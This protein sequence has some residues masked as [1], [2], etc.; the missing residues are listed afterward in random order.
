[1]NSASVLLH[2]MTQQK[3]RRP[4]EEKYRILTKNKT[5]NMM[6]VFGDTSRNIF[7]KSFSGSLCVSADGSWKGGGFREGGGRG[8]YL[9]ICKRGEGGGGGI[10]TQD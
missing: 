8:L 7:V 5:S 6:V 10:D 2:R 1:M 4:A 3:W 9:R